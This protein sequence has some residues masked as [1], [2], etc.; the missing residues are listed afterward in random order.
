MLVR[1]MHPH[2]HIWGDGSTFKGND[3]D[4]F[5]RYGAAA[6]RAADLQALARRRFRGELGGRAEMSQ[7]IAERELPYRTHR[8]GVLDDANILGRDARSQ[9]LEH[10][11][12]RWKRSN[13][14]WASSS[15]IAVAIR[16]EDVTVRFDAGRPVAIND[17]AY[18][19]AVTWSRRQMPSVPARAGHVRPDRKR[20]IE[21]KSRGIYRR[22]DGALGSP[23]SGY[24]T[25]CH[26]DTLA[27]Y[28]AEAPLGGCSTRAGGWIR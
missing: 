18:D 6:H 7:W 10:W 24:S 15:G 12:R 17:V 5:Y 2:V 9:T 21:A 3:I 22:R 14:S 13:R 19:D 25:P 16:A 20:N 26:E 23:T 28:H 27:N 1:Q 4:R 8:Q 11:T